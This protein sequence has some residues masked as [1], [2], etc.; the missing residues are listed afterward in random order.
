MS[1]PKRQ[2]KTPTQAAVIQI[3]ETFGAPIAL[4]ELY[5]FIKYSL[6]KTAFSTVFRVVRRLE[7]EG[8]VVAINWPERGS[9]YEWAGLPHHHHFVCE[10]CGTILD[11]TDTL[12]GY[13]NQYLSRQTGWQIDSHAI[14]LRGR[15]QDCQR[16]ASGSGNARPAAVPR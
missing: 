5:Q 2:R 3:L 12:I 10:G 8:K 9:R 14:E 4:G 11:L 7:Q 13:D 1:T 16:Q 15:C 6:P